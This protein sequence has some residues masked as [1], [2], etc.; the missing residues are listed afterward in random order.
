MQISDF[1]I[2]LF[3]LVLVLQ[4]PNQVIY[5]LNKIRALTFLEMFRVT[6]VSYII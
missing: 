4:F 2:N 5:E 6:F 3:P 1:F